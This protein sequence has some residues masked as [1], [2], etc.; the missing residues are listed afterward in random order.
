MDC[1]RFDEQLMDFDG[2]SEEAK[3]E[4]AQHY[5]S[6][7]RCH[8]EHPGIEWIFEDLS[9]SRPV[10]A[11]PHDLTNKV[12]SGINRANHSTVNWFKYAAATVSLILITAFAWEFTGHS[13]IAESRPLIDSSGESNHE[14]IKRIRSKQEKP[15]SLIAEFRACKANCKAKPANCDD[16][17][18]QF[19]TRNISK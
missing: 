15:T 11:Q 7:E 4:M 9:Y 6:C 14:F 18:N 8:L 5:Q 2:L 10:S 3:D 1:N 19:N 17:F 13:T 16:C 12:M